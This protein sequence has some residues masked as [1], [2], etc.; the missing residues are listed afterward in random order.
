MRP[1]NSQS[2]DPKT[3]RPR[4]FLR[5]IGIL[6]IDARLIPRPRQNVETNQ[7]GILAQMHSIL[8]NQKHEHKSITIVTTTTK[9]GR[10][11]NIP[12]LGTVDIDRTS[13][14][15]GC[16]R[17]ESLE[18]RIDIFELS[19]SA[20]H[21]YAGLGM[22]RSFRQEIVSFAQGPRERWSR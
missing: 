5:R 13:I 7:D 8:Y 17:R 6:G 1:H 21:R 14:C 12:P 18:R 9:S 10:K 3:R 20:G 22:A 11:R 4:L 2:C 19:A 16:G 15:R